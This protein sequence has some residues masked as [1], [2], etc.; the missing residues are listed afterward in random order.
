MQSLTFAKGYLIFAYRNS[1]TDIGR[2]SMK[3]PGVVA[4]GICRTL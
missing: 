4:V 2:T 3:V 1:S